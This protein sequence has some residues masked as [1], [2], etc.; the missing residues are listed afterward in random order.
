MAL[1][2]VTH[3][4]DASKK[5]ANGKNCFVVSVSSSA[6]A[7]ARAEA[8]AGEVAGTSDS[9]TWRAVAITDTPSQDFVVEGQPIG[10]RVGATWKPLSR[11]GDYLA[12]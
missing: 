12:I 5:Q 7:I 3:K 6:N 4:L 10:L 11:G 1:Y 8:M 9:A 2:V